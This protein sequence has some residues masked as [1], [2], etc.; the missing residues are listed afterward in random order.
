MRLAI[1]TD[2]FYPQINGVSNTL[3]YLSRYL[4]QRGIAHVFYAPEDKSGKTDAGEYPVVRF[5]SV[6]FAL[7]PQV[8]LSLPSQGALRRSLEAFRPDVVHIVTEFGMGYSGLKAARQMGIPVVMSYHTNFDQYLA[9]YGLTF[10]EEPLWQYM[11]WFHSFAQTNLCPSENTQ[12]TLT[13]RGIRNLA[14]WSR[15]ID[16]TRFSPEFRSESLR[17]ELGA[18]NR[19]LYLYVGRISAEKGIDVYAKSIRAFNERH[20]DRA[21]FIFTG[22]G[23]YL[24]ALKAMNI[25]NTVFT[26]ALRGRALSEI[27]A[28]CDVFVFP[29][30]N[31]TFGNVMLEAMASGTPGICVDAGGLKD[32]TAQGENACVCA[33]RDARALTEAMTAMLSGRLRETIRAG[34]LR[35]AGERSWDS[36][37]SGLLRH[38]ALALP[39]ARAV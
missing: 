35:T 6:P 27:Y 5:P 13:F 14:V 20:R 8:R 38:Y 2:T 22:D 29:S 21:R 15:G 36:I 31:E 17:R 32:F 16:R 23:P 18:D 26:G 9:H 3:Q 28:S 37:F 30:D 19:L 33:P 12:Q 10:L 24:P 4:T 11:R 1:F 7:Y 39:H 25:E 34:A